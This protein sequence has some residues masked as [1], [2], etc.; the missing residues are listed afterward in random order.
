M[1]KQVVIVSYTVTVSYLT[2]PLLGKALASARE[3]KAQ[4]AKSDWSE[5]RSIL[6]ANVNERVKEGTEW[7]NSHPTSGQLWVRVR[8]SIST[9]CK[10]WPVPKQPFAPGTRSERSCHAKPRS[11]MPENCAV[12]VLALQRSQRCGHG[13]RRKVCDGPVKLWSGVIRVFRRL[14]C[15]ERCRQ[16]QSDQWMRVKGGACGRN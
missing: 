12:N 11:A 5:G 8:W 7:K 15:G 3:K 10:R 14:E 16:Q 2:G 9:R 6:K 4:T 13:L 1:T